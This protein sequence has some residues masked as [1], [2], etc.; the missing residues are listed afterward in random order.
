MKTKKFIFQLATAQNKKNR[1]N[2]NIMIFTLAIVMLGLYSIFTLLFGKVS[3]DRVEVIRDNGTVAAGAILNGGEKQKEDIK[4]LSYIKNIGNVNKIGMWMNNNQEIAQ[5]EICDEKTFCDFFMPAYTNIVGKFPKHNDE[6]MLP[7]S[8]LKKIGIDNPYLGMNIHIAILWNDWTRNEEKATSYTMHLSGY[9]TEYLDKSV[10]EIPVYLSKKFLETENLREY[11][12][13][14][15]FEVTGKGYK[16]EELEERIVST[17]STDEGQKVVIIES[18]EYEAWRKTLGGYGIAITCGVLLLS[19]MFLLIY[20]LMLISM[21][22]NIFRIEIMNHLGMT[23][24]QIRKMLDLQKLR[25][26]TAGCVLGIIFSY[27]FVN[28]GFSYI[29]S[30]IFSKKTQIEIEKA[31]LFSRERLFLVVIIVCIIAWFAMQCAEYMIYKKNVVQIKKNTTRKALKK[32]IEKFYL[33]HLAW[34]NVTR[35]RKRY[36]ITVV[37]MAMGCIVAVSSIIILKGIDPRNQ[38]EENPDFRI[39]M[40]KTAMDEYQWEWDEEKRQEIQAILNQMVL[41]IEKIAGI[42]ENEMY[43]IEG[44][45]GN[46]DY[47]DKTLQ[48][49]V[50][51]SSRNIKTNT[52]V[53]IQSV[54]ENTL[55]ILKKYVEKYEKKIDDKLLYSDCG[56]LILHN[57]M[58]SVEQEE[59]TEK[60]VGNSLQIMNIENEDTKDLK[61]IGYLDVS[62]ENFP[63][64]E[65]AWLPQYTNYFLVSHQT[66]Q[67]LQYEKLKFGIAFDVEKY[68]EKEIKRELLQYLQNLNKNSETKLFELTANSDV[69]QEQK[70]YL[71]IGRTIATLV[72]SMLL[73]IAVMNYINTIASNMFMRR[74]EFFL[75]KN[76][77]MTKKQIWKMLI[78]EGLCYSLSSIFILLSLGNILIF[79]LVKVVSEKISYFRLF[80]PI[81]EIGTI[82]L[83]Q[84]IVCVILPIILFKRTIIPKGNYPFNH[85]D[86]TDN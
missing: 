49:L 48:P 47:T 29:L 80:Y 11:P 61:C 33:L 75:M 78:Y 10:Q 85:L 9:F 22:G 71:M 7:I 38:L 65:M 18:N 19:S 30:S 50:N 58:L 2:V 76:I 52:G 14:L 77:G 13:N 32:S 43:I 39:C 25:V 31:I 63:M 56:V 37:T 46:F 67:K 83:L 69:I 66:F 41:D 62:D 82:L 60:L 57:H 27:L 23:K 68:K 1:K 40:T 17:V 73:I 54:D 28:F 6:I 16:Q 64:I 53:T 44:G 79:L 86:K 70:E 5:I 74:R 21:A 34:Y 51:A 84:I 20:N 36:R 81:K 72:I 15:F 59:E 35:I 45:F 26:I 3:V 55:D 8:I 42:K 12:S 4:K 24:K